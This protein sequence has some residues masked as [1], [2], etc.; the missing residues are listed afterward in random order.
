MFGNVRVVNRHT[1]GVVK[2]L[3]AA[4][5]EL[6]VHIKCTDDTKRILRWNVACVTLHNILVNFGTVWP[7]DDE[8]DEEDNVDESPHNGE[9][10]SSDG[11]I[12]DGTRSRLENE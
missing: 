12:Y 5:K 9:S 11:D 2:A 10:C 8:L 6:R 3:W 7:D 1:I 4:M